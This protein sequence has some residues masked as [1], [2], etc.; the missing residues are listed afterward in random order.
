MGSFTMN[1]VLQFFSNEEEKTRQ[2]V[3]AFLAAFGRSRWLRP[4]QTRTILVVLI[5]AA[6]HPRK[7]PLLSCIYIT[8]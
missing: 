6:L 2:Q 7:F 8:K 3:A 5:F 1:I 4:N